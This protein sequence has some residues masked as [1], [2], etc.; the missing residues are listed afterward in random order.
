MT[1]RSSASMDRSALKPWMTSL[2]SSCAHKGADMNCISILPEGGGWLIAEFGGASQQEAYGK[3]K[4]LEAAFKRRPN[5]PHIK[6]AGEQARAEMIWKAREAGLGSTAFVPHHPDAW[7]G[8]EDAAVPP[9]T[10]RHLFTGAFRAL[11]NRYDYDTTL[12]GHFGDGLRALPYR[13]RPAH[14]G[15]ARKDAALPG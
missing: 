7:E 2:S 9:G 4:A 12:Y 3:A 13:F 15:G 14:H 8:W 1:P 6:I 5:P 10:S 11:L